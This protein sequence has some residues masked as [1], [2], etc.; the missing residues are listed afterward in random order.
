MITIGTSGIGVLLV[1]KLTLLSAAVGYYWHSYWHNN[2]DFLHYRTK[3]GMPTAKVFLKYIYV[4]SFILF[5]FSTVLLIITVALGF[6]GG[7]TTAIDYSLLAVSVVLALV[8]VRLLTL[9]PIT[10]WRK[11]PN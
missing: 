7:E 4:N 3:L 2:I 9:P 6:V 1:T 10:H 11:R 5:I 8:A